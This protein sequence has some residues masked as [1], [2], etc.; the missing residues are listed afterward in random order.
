MSWTYVTSA[1]GQSGT[2][3]TLSNVSSGDLIVAFGGWSGSSSSMSLSDGNGSDTFAYSTVNAATGN[4]M[5]LQIAYLLSSAATGSV[6][7][8]VTWPSGS[9]NQSFYV[10]QFHQSGGA[11][12]YD[13]GI[14]S[15]SGYTTSAGNQ[16]SGSFNTAGADLVLGAFVCYG[17]VYPTSPTIN[18]STPTGTVQ[19]GWDYYA[20]STYL[21]LGSATS[22]VTTVFDLGADSYYWC[23]SAICFKPSGGATADWL[24]EGY[25]Q[26]QNWIPYR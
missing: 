10:M 7:Y 13:T 11:C 16:S 8:T 25:W 15:A 19:A 4:N 2:T 3:A 24:T 6:A 22:G 18:G 17:T 14:Y 26:Q 21:V 9:S 5:D 1:T 12:S 20:E 23:I